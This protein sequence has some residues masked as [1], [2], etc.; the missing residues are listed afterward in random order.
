MR[1]IL[2]IDADES[3]GFRFAKDFGTR[4]KIQMLYPLRGI[5][6]FLESL[7]SL[8]DE[9]DFI[10]NNF[11]IPYYSKQYK[12]ME[13]NYKVQELINEK[14][15]KGKKILI[16][17][18][19][20]YKSSQ[21]PKNEKSAT[22]PETEYGMA[23]L[24]AEEAVRKNAHFI[25]IRSGIIYGKCTY[26]IYTDILAAIRGKIPM[27]LNNDIAINPVLN[28][29]ISLI[30][31]KVMDND[32][33]LIINAASDETMTLYEFGCKLYS[34]IHSSPC[35]FIKTY[36]G[37]KLDYTLDTSMV[38]RLYNLNFTNLEGINFL[39]FSLK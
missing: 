6:E 14:F 17:N 22:E 23:K 31:Y 18:Q 20:V 39:N 26:N 36:S 30:V 32:S 9:F 25:I 4:D 16:S 15:K 7:M 35:P 34:S 2:V 28:S 27:K 13:M 29:D 8:N 37:T 11:D 10:I 12:Y 24:K 38:H 3:F 21:S 1:R 5:E 33:N 19:L